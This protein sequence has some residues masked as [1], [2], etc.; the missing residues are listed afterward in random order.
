MSGGN[1]LHTKLMY[2]LKQ[3]NA[4]PN[5]VDNMD[6]ITSAKFVMKDY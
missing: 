1:L 5:L 6:D 3:M 4:F 2:K